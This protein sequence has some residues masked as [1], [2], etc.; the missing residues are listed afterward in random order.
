MRVDVP[1]VNYADLLIHLPEACDFI[2]EALGANDTNKVLVH[3]VQGLSRSPTV[4]AAYCESPVRNKLSIV[5][6]YI[7][8]N[9]ETADRSNRSC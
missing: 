4:V 5:L 1:D 3:C 8:S 9:E 7:R 2:D 6:N